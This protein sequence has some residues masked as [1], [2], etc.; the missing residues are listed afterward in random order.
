[1]A[2]STFARDSS[3]ECFQPTEHHG[4][5]HTVHS[6][7]II[8]CVQ[9]LRTATIRVAIA[10]EPGEKPLL[11]DSFGGR[12]SSTTFMPHLMHANTTD[13]DRNLTRPQRWVPRGCTTVGAL[14]LECPPCFTVPAVGSRPTV[15]IRAS[16]APRARAVLWWEINDYMYMY[17]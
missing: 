7:Y 5:L 4:D 11:F 17:R 6:T 2:T 1:M 15:V 3:W 14:A 13:P 12:T 10:L 9:I 16:R 8:R